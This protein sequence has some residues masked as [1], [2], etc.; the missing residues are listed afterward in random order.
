[1]AANSTGGPLPSRPFSYV[2]VTMKSNGETL[3]GFAAA[4][5]MPGLSGL[6]T[7]SYAVPKPAIRLS[8]GS[9]LIPSVS[10]W[11][12]RNDAGRRMA[13]ALQLQGMVD[14]E[15]GML[16]R[17]T[18][19][20][21]RAQIV[22]AVLAHGVYDRLRISVGPRRRRMASLNEIVPAIERCTPTIAIEGSV[23][24]RPEGAL[25][26][27]IFRPAEHR[28]PIGLVDRQA[29]PPRSASRRDRPPR[30]PR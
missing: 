24:R 15:I 11:I 18:R 6:P 30:C 23:R 9:A 5:A 29:R 16:M 1:M 22:E 27:L 12:G 19:Q 7:K 20:E 28:S 21:H 26:A 2:A 13:A 4:R 3:G 14:D 17:R 10:A 8:C 25:Q